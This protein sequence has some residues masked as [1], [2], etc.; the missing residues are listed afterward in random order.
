LIEL[1]FYVPLTGHFG[2]ILP[3]QSLGVLLKKLNV[4][5]QK[6]TTRTKNKTQNA[7]PKQI[8][9]NKPKPTLTFKNC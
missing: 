5:Q 6:Q 7:K 9:K 3:S 8:Q 2:D 1:R 4:T